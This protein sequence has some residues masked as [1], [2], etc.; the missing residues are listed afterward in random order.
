MPPLSTARPSSPPPRQISLTVNNTLTV[1]TTECR[2]TLL[3]VLR[4]Q[5]QL[6]GTKEVCSI[7]DCGACTVHLNGTAVYSCLI[8]AAECDGA[9][10]TT[11]EG[12]SRN[13]DLDPLQKAFIE[14]DALQCGYCTPGQLMNLRALFNDNPTPSDEHIYETLGGNLC[15]CGAYQNILRAAQLVREENQHGD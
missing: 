8:L 14:A 13:G 11:I 7:G 4:N 5:L 1:L 6:T 12:L 10:V 3:S 9:E 15:R 2:Q